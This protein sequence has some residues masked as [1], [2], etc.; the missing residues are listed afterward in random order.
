MY[1]EGIV[2]LSIIF[3]Y[4]SGHFD[5]SIGLKVESKSYDAIAKAIQANPSDIL[6]VSDN[7]K[8]TPYIFL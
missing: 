7:V 6:F 4:F 2:I 5:T 3:Q 1:T 8:G